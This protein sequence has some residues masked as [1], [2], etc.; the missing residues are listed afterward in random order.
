L[1]VNPRCKW[2]FR[3]TPLRDA[4]ASKTGFPV[5]L[6]EY[7]DDPYSFLKQISCGQLVAHL[8]K[9]IES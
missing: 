3:R 9:K 8:R 6:P 2:P 1:V 7:H 4:A 5:V